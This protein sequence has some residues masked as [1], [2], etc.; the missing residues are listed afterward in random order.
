MERVGWGER[1]ENRATNK[2]TPRLW[3]ITSCEV[4]QHIMYSRTVNVQRVYACV[5][6]FILRVALAFPRI[7]LLY[8]F[9]FIL[10]FKYRLSLSIALKRSCN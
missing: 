1:I 3:L 6:V 9:F 2:G 10:L 8:L 4:I 5:R 7:R